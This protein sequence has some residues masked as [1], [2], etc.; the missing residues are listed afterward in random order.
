MA[1]CRFLLVY[2][3]IY[4]SIARARARAAAGKNPQKEGIGKLLFLIKTLGRL[5]ANPSSA[6]LAKKPYWRQK[7]RVIMTIWLAPEP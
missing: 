1:C 7:T 5:P 2:L 6:V 3:P 4:A